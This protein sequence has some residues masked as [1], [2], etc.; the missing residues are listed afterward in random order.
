MGLLGGRRVRGWRSGGGFASNRQGRCGWHAAT[1]VTC[2]AAGL[3]RPDLG[4]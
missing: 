1:A 3:F 4:P 2:A